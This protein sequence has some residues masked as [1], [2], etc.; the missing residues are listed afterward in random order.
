VGVCCLQAECA[1][2]PCI[3]CTGSGR[4]RPV[5]A[6]CFQHLR[7][8]AV[9]GAAAGAQLAQLSVCRLCEL[10]LP[11]APNVMKSER[12]GCCMQHVGYVCCQSALFGFN[13]CG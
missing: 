5:V 1:G 3:S 10:R 11:C 8:C 4:Q 12:G 6:C 13:Q 2:W 7:S 9:M